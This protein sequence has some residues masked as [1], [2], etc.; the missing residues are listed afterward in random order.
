MRLF[1]RIKMS[2][3][4]RLPTHIVPINYNLVTRIDSEELKFYGIVTID[5]KVY[6][7]S[8]YS[9]LIQLNS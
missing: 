8:F 1:F 7:S 2:D 5:L 3:F 9:K 4:E 6:L